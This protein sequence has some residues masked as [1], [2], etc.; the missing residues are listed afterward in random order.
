MAGFKIDFRVAVFG[1]V[2]ML[3]LM[4]ALVIF[5]KT[6]GTA[7]VGF[8][9]PAIVLTWFSLLLMMATATALFTSVFFKWPVDLQWVL[10][11]KD[12]GTDKQST[13][14][15]KPDISPPASP[16]ASPS[17]AGLQSPP[18]EPTPSQW[19]DFVGVWESDELK[20]PLYTLPEQKCVQD[21]T[22]KFQLDVFETAPN[23]YDAKFQFQATGS[24][25]IPKA[26]DFLPTPPCSPSVPPFHGGHDFST[27]VVGVT[28]HVLSLQIDA[29]GQQLILKFKHVDRER[30]VALPGGADTL[31]NNENRA[32][33]N[34]TGFLFYRR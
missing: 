8:A 19:D 31:L 9:G 12:S 24:T 3:V 20:D 16:T 17:P 23:K 13:I 22:R 2:I 14:E 11:R 15:P 21:L 27:S 18:K 32:S 10:Q 4:T 1:T 30:I 29:W 5:A 6:A 25:H 26:G 34:G 7:S 33:L 28:N